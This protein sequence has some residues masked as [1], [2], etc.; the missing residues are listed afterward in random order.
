MYQG[1]GAEEV[2]LE[3]VVLPKVYVR[4]TSAG[5]AAGHCETYVGSASVIRPLRCLFGG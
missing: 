3:S 5:V 1:P 2:C 4:S